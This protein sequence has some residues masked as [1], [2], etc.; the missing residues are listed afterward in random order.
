MARIT[1]SRGRKRRSMVARRA[2]VAVGAAL[3]LAALGATPSL[4]ADAASCAPANGVKFICN[5]TNVEDFAPVPDTRWVFGSDLPSAADKQ[6][7]LHLFD[8][9]KDTVSNIEPS[10]IAIRPDKQ[11]YRDCP[12]APDMK[13]F[14]PHGLD[15]TP[16]RDGRAVLYVVNHGG[17]E[18]VEAFDVDLS[19]ERP[20]L[21]WTGC[22][23][24]PKGFWPDA[25]ASLP[26]GG[27]IVTSLWDPTDPHRVDKLSNGEPVG[28]L[29]EWQP[30]KGWS[31]VPGSAGMS[32]PNGV[33]VSPDGKL[34]FV[35]VWSGHK[36]TR[37]TRG[38]NPPK[39][40]SVPTGILTDNDRWSPDGKT[41]YVGGQDTTVKQV[42]S[43]FES[44][45]VNCN[46]P[47]KI[48]AMDP[49]TMKLTVLVKSGVYGVMGAG[50]GAIREGN[51]LWVSSFRSDRIALFPIKD[52]LKKPLSTRSRNSL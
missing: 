21:T 33:I 10:A 37:I 13:I 50:T 38:T 25:V 12:G 49:S 5:A 51:Q 18:S 40:D 47:F 45:Q 48:Y 26:D 24:A 6:G 16:P 39:T 8:A 44:N 32:G 11:R 52:T 20:A 36:L 23:V 2:V 35:A 19:K 42:L 7:F 17:R 29:D 43:C 3:G 4:A 9:S 46:V 1:F 31:E 28:A 34:I 15:L 30:S 27:L 14:A 22:V 41:I